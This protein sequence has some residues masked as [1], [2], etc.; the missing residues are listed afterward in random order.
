MLPL[1]LQTAVSKPAGISL[2]TKRLPMLYQNMW[3]LETQ[4]T[5]E[6]VMASGLL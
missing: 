6:I 4:V 2:G 3:I 1:V 5:S